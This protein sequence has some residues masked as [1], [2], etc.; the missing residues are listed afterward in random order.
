MIYS[1]TLGKRAGETKVLPVDWERLPAEAQAKIIAY[2]VQRTFNDA[3]GGGD[4]SIDDKVKIASGMIADY[5]QGKI[6]RKRAEGVS[7]EVAIGRQLV[8]AAL[9]DKLGGKSPEWKAFIGLS[10]D[11]QNA[12]LDA[13]A[14]KHGEK[15]A[16]QVAKEIA[17]RAAKPK[18]D[19]DMDF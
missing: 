7:D 5:Y 11:A 4:L 12:K 2:G 19:L 16:A 18:L 1:V 14:A 8:R 17:R 15:L 3:V 13:L 9:K 6:G 10:E